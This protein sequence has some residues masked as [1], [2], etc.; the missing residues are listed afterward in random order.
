MKALVTKDIHPRVI[1]VEYGWWFPEKAAPDHGVWE[2]NANMLTNDGPPYDPAFGSY[3]LRGLLC[4]IE[5][6][7]A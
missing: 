7:T 4:R 2:S 5:R 1:N 3:Q 6:E